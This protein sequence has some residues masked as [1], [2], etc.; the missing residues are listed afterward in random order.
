MTTIFVS[1]GQCGN[2]LANTLLQ[3]LDSNN[4][5]NQQTAYLF[6]F[7]DQKFRFV[8]LDSETKVISGLLSEHR[9]KIRPENLVNAKCGRGSNWAAGYAGLDK[10]SSLKIIDRCMESVRREAERSDFLLNFNLMHSLSGGTG[11]G[12][13]S[14]LIEHLREEYGY[15]K[16]MFMQSVAPFRHGELPL[17]HYN[18]LLCLSLLHEFTD[19]IYLH[20][21]DDVLSFIE[22]IQNEANRAS[23]AGSMKLPPIAMNPRVH[24]KTTPAGAS[25][26]QDSISFDDMNSFIIKNFLSCIFPVDN[27]SL[28]TQSIG[29]EQLEL[30][31]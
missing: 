17:Q 31:R 25:T 10:E 26:E 11:S 9:E 4:E 18:N 5:R 22:K 14:R 30:H 20:Q 6:K 24:K 28:K 12:C 1:V 16:Y 3:Y 23:S 27:V 19:A 13:T 2:Q 29:M 15:K 21:N 8:A 7:N